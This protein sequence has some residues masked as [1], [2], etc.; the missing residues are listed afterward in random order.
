MN[1]ITRRAIRTAIGVLAVGAIAVAMAG[2]ALASHVAVQTTVPDEG[3]VGEVLLSTVDLRAGDGTPLQGTTVIFYLHMS[4]AG[5]VGEAEIGRAVTDETGVA[6]LAYRPRLAGHHELRMEY[7][8]PGDGEVEATST[9]FDVTGGQQ[10]YRSAAGIDVPG[11]DAGLLM[12]VL[13][14]VW[15]ILFWVALRFVAIARAGGE[16]RTP[17]LYQTP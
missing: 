16:A 11:V 17:G 13:A 4:F 12:A 3:T 7:V 15:S 10:L 2:P 9:S 6:T 8:T 1:V 14:T 5:V